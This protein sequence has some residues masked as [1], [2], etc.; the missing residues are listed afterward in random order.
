MADDTRKQNINEIKS[1]L[2][3]KKN[4]TTTINGNGERRNKI[5]KDFLI[6]WNMYTDT[7][8]EINTVWHQWHTGSVGEKMLKGDWHTIRLF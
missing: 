6:R 5:N 2:K 7:Q 1:K 4:T 3:Q 8:I